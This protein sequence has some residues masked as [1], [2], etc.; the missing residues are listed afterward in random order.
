MRARNERGKESEV[1]E[2]NRGIFSEAVSCL[3]LATSI[4]EPMVSTGNTKTFLRTSSL[5]EILQEMYI[6]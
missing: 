2:E 4:T 6:Q 3:L 1:K 5:A